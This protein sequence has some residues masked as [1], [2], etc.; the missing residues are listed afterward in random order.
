VIPRSALAI[1][2]KTRKPRANDCISLIMSPEL[3]A[4]F[5]TKSAFIHKM[6]RFV[7]NA[8]Q[9]VYY[10]DIAF[11]RHSMTIHVCV[12]FAQIASTLLLLKLGLL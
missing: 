2:S 12:P 5:T 7:D 9:R 3:V 4:L 10:L 11:A 1:T 8:A 6:P